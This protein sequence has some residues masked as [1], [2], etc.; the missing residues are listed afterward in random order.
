MGAP[1]TS[2]VQQA[3]PEAATPK[4]KRGRAP[5]RRRFTDT[6]IGTLTLQ[7]GSLLAFL[8]A[9]ELSVT[10]G[11]VNE[12]LVPAPSSIFEQLAEDTVS[13]FTGGAMLGHFMTTLTEVVVGF[14]FASVLAIVVGVLLSEFTL[15][16]KAVYPYVIALSA[17]PRIAFAPLFIVWF[18]FGLTSKVVMVA[19]IA[20]F[21]VLVNTMAGMDATDRDSLKLMRSLGATRWQTFRRLKVPTSLPFVFAGL[22]SGIIFAAVGAVVAEFTGGSEGLGYLTLVGQELFRLDLA[23][24]AIVF[25]ALQGVLL[26]RLII[27]GRR[28]VVF[29]QNPAN[30]ATAKR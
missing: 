1:M 11:V 27:I 16:R 12:I 4:G 19:A 2:D 29:W 26:H 10:T 23:F 18:G 6:R 30:E 8:A 3:L 24:S 25:L 14:V 15:F 28:R 9:W 22:E 13:L 5:S 20:A 17:T 7:V 21:P